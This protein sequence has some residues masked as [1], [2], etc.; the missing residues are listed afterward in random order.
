MRSL[1]IAVEG[2]LDESV[3]KKMGERLGFDV[4]EVSGKQGRQYLLDRIGAYRGRAEHAPWAVL[5]DR[6]DDPCPSSLRDE[7]L[8]HGLGNLTFRVAVEEI[9]SWIMA[10]RLAFAEFL[11]VEQRH[12]PANTDAIHRPKEF[13]VE[14]ASRSCKQEIRQGLVP[15]PGSRSKVGP[16]YNIMLIE[17]VE[18]QWKCDNASR[19]SKSLAR[20]M[21]R[22][23]RYLQLFAAR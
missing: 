20:A 13:L 9:E 21:E 11:G 12:L 7:Y 5:I 6:D 23:P 1:N 10:D 22:I 4:D 8:P 17:F 16:E 18:A 19:S 15:P 14:L 3:L 2:P